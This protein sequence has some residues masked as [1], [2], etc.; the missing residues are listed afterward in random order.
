[1]TW[2]ASRPYGGEAVMRGNAGHWLVLVE[3]RAFTPED[4][5]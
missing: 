2:L 1:V 4:F 5:T 3:S